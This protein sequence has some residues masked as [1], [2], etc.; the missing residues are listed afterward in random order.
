MVMLKMVHV[1]VAAA[2]FGHKLLVPFD[3]RDAVLQRI[4]PAFVARIE[5]AQNLGIASGLATLASGLSLLFWIGPGEVRPAIH[6]GLVVAVAM[7]VVGAVVAR[8]AWSLVKRGIESD[9]PESVRAGAA[10]LSGALGLESALW[11][12]VLATMLV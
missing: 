6:I 10:R 2:W 9:D 3:L 7:F 1:V 8:P 5:R 4:D 11:V 12:V